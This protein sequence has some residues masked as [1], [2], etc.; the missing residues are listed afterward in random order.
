MNF[1]LV[2]CGRIA[3]KHC[4]ALSKHLDSTTLIAVCDTDPVRA[5]NTGKQYG[6][7]WYTQYHEMM[8][9]H[10]ELDVV[11]I[12]TPS[13]LHCQHVLDLAPY[14]KHLVVEKPMALTLPDAEKMLRACDEAGVQLF[15]VKQ[16]RTNP[17]IL[18]LREALV[19]GRFG[20]LVMGTVR[21]RW[22]RNQNY[23]DQ[24]SWRGTWAMDGGVLMNQASHHVDLLTWMMGDVDSVFAY[25]ATRLVKIETEDTA[26]AVLRFHNGA[27]G[28]VEATTAAR[29]IDLEGS[30]SILGENGAVEVGGFAVNEIKTWNFKDSSAEETTNAKKIVET[31]PNVY[32]YGHVNYLANVV[33]SIRTRKLSAVDGIEGMKS[34]ILINAMY[35]SMETGRD[36][37]LLFQPKNVR[38]GRTG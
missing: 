4:E 11:N 20:K 36:V 14:G 18:K 29:P 22:C 15:V 25:S 27:L 38:L 9:K 37:P 21:V 28:I 17:P 3:S 24:D 10:P 7:K 33:K 6:V 12:L 19:A 16:N 30:I 35:E 8:E 1:A 32:G 34:L 23:Y 5:E 26:V 31:P 13:G 2:G